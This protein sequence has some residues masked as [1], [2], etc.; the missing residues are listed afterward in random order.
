MNNND[1]DNDDIHYRLIANHEHLKNRNRVYKTNYL[2]LYIE[3][4]FQ[5][6]KSTTK[7]LINYIEN[8]INKINITDFIVEDIL[9]ETIKDIENGSIH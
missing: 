3:K 8:F 1:N 9:N 5:C 6:D 2:Q 4:K 7:N